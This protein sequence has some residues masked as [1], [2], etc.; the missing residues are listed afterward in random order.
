MVG[1]GSAVFGLGGRVD[2]KRVDGK[3]IDV[4]GLEDERTDKKRD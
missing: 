1:I 3:T 4:T 2:G